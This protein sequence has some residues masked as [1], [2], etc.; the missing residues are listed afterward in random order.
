MDL[1]E[2]QFRLG[3]TQRKQKGVP[4]TTGVHIEAIHTP[5]DEDAGSLHFR[6]MSDQ[7]GQPGKHWAALLVYIHMDHEQQGLAMEMVR[8]LTNMMP[9]STFNWHNFSSEGG[10]AVARKAV[11]ENPRQHILQ[12]DFLRGD[13]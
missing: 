4:V 9:N 3:Y 1:N 12:E 6:R 13:L 2:Y 11:S 10:L 7:P 8:R 5:T